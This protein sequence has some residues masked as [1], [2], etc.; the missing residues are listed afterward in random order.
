MDIALFSILYFCFLV[1]LTLLNFY[2]IGFESLNFDIEFLFHMCCLMNC[3]RELAIPNL[4]MIELIRSG[5]IPQLY[6][7]DCMLGE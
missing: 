6:E 2:D 5:C 3:H 4:Y 7:H 1:N